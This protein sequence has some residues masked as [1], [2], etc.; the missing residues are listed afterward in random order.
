MQF[1]PEELIFMDMNQTLQMVNMLSNT[2]GLYENEKRAAFGKQPLPELVGKR[3]MSLNWVDVDIAAQY[4]LNGKQ[5]EN[6]NT[7]KDGTEEKG[8]I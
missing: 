2:G 3:Y 4:Q 5:P 6:S 7:S 8:E 1:Y